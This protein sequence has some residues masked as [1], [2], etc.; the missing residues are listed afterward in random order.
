MSPA[1]KLPLQDIPRLTFGMVPSSDDAR[2]RLTLGDFCDMLGRS[3]QTTVVPHRAPSPGALASAI[4][5]GRVQLAWLSPTLMSTSEQL[6]SVI[7]LVS[8]VR[9]GVTAYHAAL[10]VSEASP[11]RSVDQLS[12][13]RAAWVAPTSASGYLF[14]RV[15]LLRRGLDPRRLFG[16]ET[17]YD[18]HGAVARAVLERRADVGATFAVYER[19]DPHRRLV[20]AGFLGVVPGRLAR[21]IDVTGPIP[22]DVIV[23]TR[24]TPGLARSAIS[25]ALRRIGDDPAALPALQVLFGVEGFQPFSA[26][27]LPA[28][29]ALVDLGREAGLITKAIA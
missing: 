9:E 25:I 26:A 7:P 18:A 5:A 28:L 17:F 2:T 27:S 24:S 22:S 20:R 21:V 19:A 12:G 4:Q 13:A 16:R 3:L 14:S 29:R 1:R 10:F 15:A 6:S 8:S 23:A 11:V